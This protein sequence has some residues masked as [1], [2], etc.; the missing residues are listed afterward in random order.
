[1]LKHCFFSRNSPWLE[2]LHGSEDSDTLWIQLTFCC[3]YLSILI[4]FIIFRKHLSALVFKTCISQNWLISLLHNS[5]QNEQLNSR[6]SYTG[7]NLLNI[8]KNVCLVAERLIIVHYIVKL[9]RID[10]N[11]ILTF[12]HSI[13]IH[14]YNRGCDETALHLLTAI[15]MVGL[16]S[17]IPCDISASLVWLLSK[18]VYAWSLG[19]WPASNW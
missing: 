17:I 18:M 11:I 10:M 3:K 5:Y 19:S 8:R 4:N 6:I 9:L 7:S 16:H 14:H 2:F 12:G 15:D 13:F 1:M